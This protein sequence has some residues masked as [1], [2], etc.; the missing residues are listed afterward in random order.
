MADQ[1]DD[2]FE[3]LKTFLGV[4][5]ERYMSIE[6]LPP[7]HRPLAC[8]EYVEKTFGMKRARSSLQVA[9]NDIIA[10]SDRF[11][12]EEVR[13]LDAD[14]RA[15]GVITLSELRVRFSKKYRSIIRRGKIRTVEEYYLLKEIVDASIEVPAEARSTIEGILV[16][17]EERAIN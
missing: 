16:D 6:R 2:D 7:E 17:F 1:P 8:L 9:I 4:F 13:S 3:R 11:D 15:N 14:L 10:R 5:S 12:F